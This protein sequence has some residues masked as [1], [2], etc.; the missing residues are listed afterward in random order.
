MIFRFDP[1]DGIPVINRRAP[2]RGALIPEWHGHRRRVE[3][4]HVFPAVLN[5]PVKVM[6]W[7]TTIDDRCIP[8][9]V[10]FF[11]ELAGDQVSDLARAPER[12]FDELSR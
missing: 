3:S 9:T 11:V 2:Q 8:A 7:T 6:N 1:T 12:L 10:G 4:S 5:K